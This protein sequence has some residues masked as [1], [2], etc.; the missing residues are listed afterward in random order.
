MLNVQKNKVFKIDLDWFVGHDEI[1]SVVVGRFAFKVDINSNLSQKT[2]SK[3]YS[4]GKPYIVIEG[5][6]N[7]TQE[8]IKEVIEKP[9]QKV[10]KKS[11]KKNTK[12]DEP[13]ESKSENYIN[14]SDKEES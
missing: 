1:E 7:K 6:E 4:Q 2:L 14:N 9:I 11:K 3:L 13:K 5:E 8:V 10:I 12:I